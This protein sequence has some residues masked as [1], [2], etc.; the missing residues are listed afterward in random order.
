MK[1]RQVT[2]SRLGSTGEGQEL[3]FHVLVDV[4]GIDVGLE[5]GSPEGIPKT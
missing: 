4:E 2:D 1:N 5:A 3:F